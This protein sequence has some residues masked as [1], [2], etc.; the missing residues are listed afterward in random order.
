[1]KNADL[2]IEIDQRKAAFV[3]EMKS[4]VKRKH[5]FRI[6]FMVRRYHDSLIRL[7]KSFWEIDKE[8]NNAKRDK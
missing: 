1:M 3:E 4:V 6:D 8:K 2:L 7:L 5:K